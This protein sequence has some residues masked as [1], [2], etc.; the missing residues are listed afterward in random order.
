MKKL[1]ITTI[2]VLVLL[3]LGY[4]LFFNRNTKECEG[5]YCDFLSQIE[6]EF[7]LTGGEKDQGYRFLRD[8]SEQ[9]TTT[10]RVIIRSI[11]GI[12]FAYPAESGWYAQQKGADEKITLNELGHALAEKEIEYEAKIQELLDSK[13]RAYK[14]EIK[15]AYSWR[16][17]RLSKQGI[18]LVDT[19]IFNNLKIDTSFLSDE[20]KTLRR[21]EMPF[22]DFTSKVNGSDKLFKGD[23]GVHGERPKVGFYNNKKEFYP[24]TEWGYSIYEME[25]TEAKLNE[26]SYNKRVEYLTTNKIVETSLIER[27]SYDR[28]LYFSYECSPLIYVP[29]E[30]KWFGPDKLKE[31][32]KKYGLI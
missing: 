5:L 7:E 17:D 18:P 1:L 12:Y 19:A 28:S 26:L 10:N 20:L 27:S 24:I 21:G 25:L 9:D 11:D 8:H 31:I 6:K 16:T 32:I 4:F 2:A 22:Y 23:T 29:A 30:K 3:F 15:R 14:A 13:L